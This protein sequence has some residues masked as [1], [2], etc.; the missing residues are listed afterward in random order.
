MYLHMIMCFLFWTGFEMMFMALFYPL[1]LSYLLV[2]PSLEA[3]SPRDAG[4]GDTSTFPT[5]SK[6][7]QLGSSVHC[8]KVVIFILRKS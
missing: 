1:S 5:Q 8:G 2:L 7:D 4:T 3:I 6:V